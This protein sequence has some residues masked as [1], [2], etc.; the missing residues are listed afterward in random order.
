M[1]HYSLIPIRLRSHFSSLSQF[2]RSI[3]HTPNKTK[4]PILHTSNTGK[5]TATLQLF[6]WGR[7]NS[8]QLG[9]GI[10]EIKIYPCPVA[11]LFLPPSFRLSSPIPDRL[12]KPGG[13]ATVEVGIS[14]GLFH[15]ALVVEGKCWIWGKGDGGRLGFGHENPVFVP[16]L[17][18]NLDNV[19]SIA[20][21]GLHSVG[22]NSVGQV[23]TWSVLY[24][25]NWCSFFF[26]FQIKSLHY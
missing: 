9:G 20:L 13:G 12:S 19:K 14:C 18:P 7:G 25:I 2:Y 16:T 5:E 4:I 8:G 24:S 6:S 11:S 26:S 1:P 10:E 3:S 17:N 21:G 23:F 22:L 15:S